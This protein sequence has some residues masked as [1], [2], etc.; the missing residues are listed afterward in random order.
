MGRAQHTSAAGY[1][2][3]KILFDNPWLVA[4]TRWR[5]AGEAP[6]PRSGNTLCCFGEHLDASCVVLSV[7]CRCCSMTGSAGSHNAAAVHG[8]ERCTVPPAGRLVTV[9]LSWQRAPPCCS[10][11]PSC[12]REP[13]AAASCS[14]LL[15]LPVRCHMLG[16]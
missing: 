1:T 9:E 16:R 6:H 10:H 11:T 13:P 7:P 15:A 14:R 12:L 3:L 4:V 5:L 8:A 2:E